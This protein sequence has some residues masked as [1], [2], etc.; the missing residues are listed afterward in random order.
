M[1]YGWYIWLCDV[2]VVQKIVKVMTLID[3]QNIVSHV[4]A[5]HVFKKPYR[6]VNHGNLKICV[7]VG[8]SV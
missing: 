7:G 2:F 6:H 1:R 8:V 3:L 4:D 5:F